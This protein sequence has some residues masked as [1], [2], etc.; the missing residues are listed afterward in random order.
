MKYSYIAACM[1]LCLTACSNEEPNPE[2]EEVETTP[3]AT[4]PTYSPEDLPT[5][6]YDIPNYDGSVATDSADD[7]PDYDDADLYYEA[8]SWTNTV[9]VTYAD[10]TAAVEG[11]TSDIT[12]TI[13]GANVDLNLGSSAQVKVVVTGRSDAGSLRISGERKHMLELDNL[14]LTATDRPAINDQVGKR[15]FVNTIGT[16]TLTDG[17]NYISTTEDRKGCFFSEGHVILSGSGVLKVTG[18]WRH[19]F[20]VDGFLYVR[21]GATLAV[22]DAAKNAIHVKGAGENNS[23]R[24]VEIAGG[25]VYANTSA[26]AGRAIKTDRNVRIH[27]G[28]LCLNCSGDAA[29][30]S[31]DGTLNSAA[32]IKADGDVVINGG[33][34][35]LTATGNGAKGIKTDGSFRIYNGTANIALRGDAVSDVDSA[36][37]KGVKSDAAVTLA[38]GRLNISAIGHGAQGIDCDSN[39][40]ISGGV[41]Y[42]FGRSY[43]LRAANGVSVGPDS[44]ATA[45]VGGKSN[46]DFG[47]K[48]SL[49]DLAADS[50]SYVVEYS[51]EASATAPAAVG[52]FRW[53]VAMTE[54]TLVFLSGTVST[55][56]LYN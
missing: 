14:T 41:L 15:V 11:L 55:P 39:I 10:A 13:S 52:V 32:C 6:S 34:L 24:G 17:A 12:A 54:A 2:I 31:E 21:P 23:Y 3:E 56:V 22:L 42:A 47:T 50:L 44:G 43:G 7:L 5:F 46:S 33:N 35:A 30:D 19:G 18:R 38:G 20:A 27:G 45:I 26:P 28:T 36:T 51:D 4:T 16:T 49:V 9:K 48:F 53:P 29:L 25:Y 1:A 40:L 8:N 37:P